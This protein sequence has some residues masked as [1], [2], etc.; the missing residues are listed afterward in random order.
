MARTKEFDT[1]DVVLKAIE[2]FWSKGFEATSISDLVE[3]MGINRGSIYD[4]FGD[5]AGLFEL[6][7]QRYQIDAPSQRLL[8]NAE[9]GDPR[10]EIELFFNALLSR[11]DCP[12][13]FRGCLIT[14]SITELAARD[15]KMAALFKA[16]VKRIEDAFFTL[17]RRGQE[18]GDIAPWREARSLARS[19]LAS[20]QGLIVVSKVEPGRE[21]LADIAETA[22][23]LLD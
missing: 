21:T 1:D 23:S 16:G 9:T 2:V 6:A 22:L 7:I 3:A 8:D 11:S 20:A 10:E 13:G 14:N 5:K 15:A 18:T 4:T 17:I 19:L 12:E